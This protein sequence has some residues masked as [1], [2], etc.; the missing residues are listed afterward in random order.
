MN[1]VSLKTPLNKLKIKIP[2]DEE[3][4]SPIHLYTDKAATKP[5]HN[6]IFHS[7]PITSNIIFF[8]K[9]C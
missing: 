2:N 3:I 9:I 7:P 6:F 8:L 1:R 4:D 5:D